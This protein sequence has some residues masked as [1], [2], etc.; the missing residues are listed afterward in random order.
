MF[1]SN[2]TEDT[3]THTSKHSNI[4]YNP[5]HVVTI[6]KSIVFAEFAQ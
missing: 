5:K 3:R 6:T 4:S 2:E 1:V